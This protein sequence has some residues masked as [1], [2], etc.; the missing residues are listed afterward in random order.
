M[1]APPH[2]AKLH[3]CRRAFSEGGKTD[4]KTEKTHEIQGVIYI[5][6]LKFWSEM[7]MKDG[8]KRKSGW[9]GE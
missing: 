5:F 6:Y 8:E 3:F 1:K 4:G 7:S 2:E 9:R